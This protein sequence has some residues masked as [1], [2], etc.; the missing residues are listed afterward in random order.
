[1]PPQYKSVLEEQ[2]RKGERLPV[3]WPWRLLTFMGV[4][5][6]MVVLAYVGMT[7]GYKTYL[8][9]R[10][11]NLDARIEELNKSLEEGKEKNLTNTYSQLVNIQTLL[12]SH[13]MPS[14]LF[15]ILEKNTH[16]RAYYNNFNLAVPEKILKIEG[17]APDY[18]SVTEQMELYR[19]IP[20][21]KSVFLDDSSLKE[22]GSIRFVIRLLIKPEIFKK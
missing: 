14:K 10:I 9:A 21:I 18:K 3:G 11:K 16:P 6:G 15:E 5:L 22:D 17:I 20:E 12:A 19:R 2:L 1:M 8:N 4:A 7:L 13:P